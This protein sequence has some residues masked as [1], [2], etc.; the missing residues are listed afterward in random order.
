MKKFFS[1]VLIIAFVA[2]VYLWLV[3]SPTV[4]HWNHKAPLTS[5]PDSANP[6]FQKLDTF[7]T[8]RS[9]QNGFSGS[10]LISKNGNCV[11]NKC[12]GYCDYR[13]KNLMSDTNSF[14][15]AS[16]SKTFTATA[17][18]WCAEHD[19]LSLDDELQKFFPQ[20]PYAQVRIKDLLSHRSGLPNYLYFCSRKCN[21]G[22]Y[23]NNE[24][25]LAIMQTEKPAPYALPNRKFE[26]CNTNYLLLALVVEKVSGKKF[27][28]FMRETFF[29][30]LEMEHT[31]IYNHEDSLSRKIA[32]SYNSKWEIQQ[33]D[34]FDGVVGD[35]GVYSTV[36]DIFK[37]DKAF[38]DGKLLSQQMM[39]QAYAPRSF[40][41]P[42]KRNYGYGWRLLQQPDGNY[43]VYHNGWW[44][45]NNTVFYRYIQD[46]TAVIILSN[47]Y[48]KWV[49]GVQ[50]V[51]NILYGNKNG[52]GGFSEE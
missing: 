7:F 9:L 27:S 31:F 28:A 16:V 11:Y 5:L 29:E 49:Y 18:L 15:L 21:K 43:L 6:Y 37:W 42:G 19:M 51:F 8:N 44:H 39:K 13:S 47:R 30:P 52:D 23:L 17:V 40:E 32:V 14:Q 22:E 36:S 33:D 50:P 26:Y 12:F 34:C 46:T 20:F 25:V 41:H 10:V 2:G 1:V 48:N 4:K 38:Y 24:Q 35:K 45:G 3:K